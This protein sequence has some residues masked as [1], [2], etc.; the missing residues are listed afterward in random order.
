MLSESDIMD[1]HQFILD[2]GYLRDL[3]SKAE[4]KALLK[5]NMILYT[6][7]VDGSFVPVWKAE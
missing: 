4:L 2:Q 5:H 7:T 1:I 3:P 6:K